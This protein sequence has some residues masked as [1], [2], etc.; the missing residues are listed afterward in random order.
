MVQCFYLPL[1]MLS[2]KWLSDKMKNKIPEFP[3][4]ILDGLLMKFKS[5]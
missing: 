2:A 5:R 4:H 1:I 3:N